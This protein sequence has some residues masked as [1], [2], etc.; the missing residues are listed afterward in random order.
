MWGFFDKSFLGLPP[1]V[2]TDTDTRNLL[3]FDDF[4]TLPL[5]VFPNV[6]HIS[7]KFSYAK[8]SSTTSK[9]I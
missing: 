9:L 6:F 4:V 7:L 5:V 1:F 2:L 8:D 3:P